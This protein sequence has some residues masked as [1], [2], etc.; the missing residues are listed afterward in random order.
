MIGAT[1]K[2]TTAAS[3]DGD[4][5]TDAAGD[6]PVQ[7][8]E[9]YPSIHCDWVRLPA[10]LA[11]SKGIADYQLTSDGVAMRKAPTLYHAADRRIGANGG[12]AMGTT[13]RLVCTSY[14]SKGSLFHEKVD[15]GG[16]ESRM[17]RL[18]VGTG[19]GGIIMGT[20]KNINCVRSRQSHR[21]RRMCTSLS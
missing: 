7:F 19:N 6:L 13:S 16:G 8:G 3:G 18:N 9:Q 20:E 21:G 12:G 14:Q 15:V 10:S 4:D 17:Y 11:S 1:E 5:A 2:V